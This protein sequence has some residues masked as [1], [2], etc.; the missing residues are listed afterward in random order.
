MEKIYGEA[1]QNEKSKQSS[2]DMLYTKGM[3]G[4]I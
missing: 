3:Y 2:R 1:F 4:M